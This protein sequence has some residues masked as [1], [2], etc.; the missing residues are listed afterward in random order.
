MTNQEL[1]DAF[2]VLIEDAKRKM[3]NA[4]PTEIFAEVFSFVHV[5]ALFNWK[6]YCQCVC[7]LYKMKSN[8]LF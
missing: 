8:N 4:T 6:Y 3:P 7:I 2:K 1:E 5:I